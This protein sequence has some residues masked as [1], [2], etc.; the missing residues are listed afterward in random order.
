MSIRPRDRKFAT[1][2]FEKVHQLA[3]KMLE[4]FGIGYPRSGFDVGPGWLPVVRDML[5]EMKSAGWDGELFQVKQKVRGLRV[6][7]DSVSGPV[8]DIIS[9]AEA[10]ALRTCELCGGSRDGGIGWGWA[11]C[12]VCGQEESP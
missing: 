3:A 4:E 1:E 11:L 6:Y 7:V 2:E 8:G 10:R 12:D 5:Q 9:R